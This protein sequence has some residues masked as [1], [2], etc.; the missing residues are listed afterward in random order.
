MDT[1]LSRVNT[2]YALMPNISLAASS[3]AEG[4]VLPSSTPL[5]TDSCHTAHAR[6]TCLTAMDTSLSRVNTG[7]ALMPNI[8]LAASSKAEGSVLP[9]STPLHTDS[10]HTAH[11][12]L[13]CLTAMDTSLSRVNT[14]YALMPNISL[15]ASSKAEG[16]VLPS[17]TP[18]H[19]DS[20]HTAHA[21]L[22]CLTAMDTSLS[23]VNTGYALMPNIS[24]AASSKAEGSVL[25]SSTPLHTDSCH[26]AHARLTC[27]TAMDTS[28]SRVNTGYALMPNISLA[29]S[30]KAEGSVLPSSTPLH[31]DSCH[32]AHARLTCLTAMDTSL[33]R[34]NTGYA[35][36][37]NI[38]LAASSKAEG[39]V[40]PSS[41]PFTSSRSAL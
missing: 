35:L 34:V 28:L 30:S 18:L 36:M 37:P 40:L 11:T 19:T 1:S 39:S 10:C 27:L 41:T 24:L 22:T 17:S 38:S 29:A 8:S 5:H 16:S 12:R 15:A 7:Y 32:T 33:S 25:P 20:C 3:K 14:G 2:G 23:R 4:S 31:T 26:T 13:T 21:R 9:S 6:L